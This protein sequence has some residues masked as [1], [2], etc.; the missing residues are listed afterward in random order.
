[1]GI[2]L[3]IIYFLSSLYVL[4]CQALFALH[5][6]VLL[7]SIVSHHLPT[8][9]SIYRENAFCLFNF[10]LYYSHNQPFTSSL[11][12]PIFG[13]LSFFPVAQVAHSPLVYPTLLPQPTLVLYSVQLIRST[14]LQDHDPNSEIHLSSQL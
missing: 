2:S 10:S 3:Y 9:F 11:P 13:K 12:A 14:R 4:T 8:L 6:V 7:Q 1:M 5:L